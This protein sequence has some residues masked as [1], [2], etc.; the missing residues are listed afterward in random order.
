MDFPDG[1]LW[2]SA[3]SAH[4]VEG[5]NTNNDWWD[6]EHQP[7]SA[8]QASSG[9]GIDHFHRYADDFALLRSLGH[10]A[11][12]L[13]IEWSR[14]E[15]APGEFSRTAIAHYRRVLTALARTGMTAFVT[16]HH[17]TLP[18]WFAARGGWLAPD[19]IDVFTRYCARVTAELGSL[20]PYI[21]TINE[22]QMIALHGYLEGYPPGRPR[23]G[24][25]R[26]CRCARVPALVGV[27]QFRVERGVPTTAVTTRA[28][29]RT[30]RTASPLSTCSRRAAA[31]MVAII[32]RSA[33]S[34]R[35]RSPPGSA[36]GRRSSPHQ[37]RPG[38]VAPQRG[39]RS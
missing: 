1:F 30:W 11:H 36:R 10:N 2:G 23:P 29:R 9:D 35:G 32:G 18:R 26:R 24:P 21:C 13:S 28:P 38:R 14:I 16:L 22:P 27:R 34:R 5:G 6:F 12:R 25:R 19:A 7:W 33:R 39:N 8:A 4:Q 15:P 17:F 3:T 31:A 20:M 37:R